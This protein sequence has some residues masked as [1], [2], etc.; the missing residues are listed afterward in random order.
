MSVLPQELI[1]LCVDFLAADRNTPALSAASM[2]STSINERCRYHKFARVTIT[3]PL[4]QVSPGSLRALK[5]AQT[6]VSVLV[7]TPSIKIYIRHFSIVFWGA[8]IGAE[9]LALLNEISSPQCQLQTIHFL[10]PSISNVFPNSATFHEALAK[11]MKMSTHHTLELV[12]VL[13]APLWLLYSKSL[14]HLRLIES[15]MRGANDQIGPS[16]SDNPLNLQSLNIH[17]FITEFLKAIPV[18]RGLQP[19][20]SSLQHL[21]ISIAGASDAHA[22]MG[23]MAQAGGNLIKVIIRIASTKLALPTCFDTPFDLA[24]CPRLQSFVIYL[25]IA[26][27]LRYPA[28]ENETLFCLSSINTSVRHLKIGQSWQS[29]TLTTFNSVEDDLYGWRLLD[30]FLNGPCVPNLLDLQI[31]VA[32]HREDTGRTINEIKVET[33]ELLEKF[34]PHMPSERKI[35]YT[36]WVG[37]N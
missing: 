36:K 33:E 18:E 3:V 15:T 13:N 1:D 9:L 20:L 32:V 8:E 5:N 7:E 14:Q 19:L 29:S 27:N 34:I 6:L 4:D 16:A 30:D 22:F 21:E 35:G 23:I 26:K 24:L 25:N 17:R 10:M 2:A 37:V 12:D 28:M 11:L 31:E